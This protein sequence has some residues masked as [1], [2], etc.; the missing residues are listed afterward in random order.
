[1]KG[2]TLLIAG[3]LTLALA[4]CSS[5]RMVEL[6]QF[7]PQK[8]MEVPKFALKKHDANVGV[9]Y[10]KSSDYGEALSY[11]T[12]MAAADVCK[13]SN[14]EVRSNTTTTSAHNSKGAQSRTAITG[15][16]I[17]QSKCKTLLGDI[18][19]DEMVV[20][21]EKKRLMFHAWVLIKSDNVAPII[22]NDFSVEDANI[23]SSL[24][25]D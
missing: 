3:A 12:H 13:K 18:E 22:E 1:M 2:K 16:S 4:G 14:L 7:E 8:E 21:Q 5:T 6:D 15:R 25:I 20:K 23:A 17:T 11:A 19:P 9:G 24:S 10:A